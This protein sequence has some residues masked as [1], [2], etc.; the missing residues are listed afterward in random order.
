L[1]QEIDGAQAGLRASLEGEI[2]DLRQQLTE[3][4]VI[5]AELR[6]A[7]AERARSGIIRP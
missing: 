5:V 7:H 2:T 4:R 3:L 6:G 1:R